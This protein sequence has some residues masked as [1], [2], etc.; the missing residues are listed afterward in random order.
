MELNTLQESASSISRMTKTFFDQT[1]ENERPIENE[2]K[3]LVKNSNPSPEDIIRKLQPLFTIYDI[4]IHP[5]LIS[6][7]IDT[8]KLD[9]NKSALSL[10][11]RGNSHTL[12]SQELFEIDS[13]KDI[14][15]KT[16]PTIISSASN[17][18]K[19]YEY[20]VEYDSDINSLDTLDFTELKMK[21]PSHDLFNRHL[22]KCLEIAENKSLKEW[23]R[24]SVNRTRVLMSPYSYKESLVVGELNIDHVRTL[25]PMTRKEIC[26][27][28]TEIE[29]EILHKECPWNEQKSVITENCSQRE[30]SKAFNLVAMFINKLPN[31]T[32]TT[33]SKADRGFSL[34]L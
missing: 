28:Y 6:R 10:R 20:E 8:N 5:F 21:Y 25:D 18:T 11:I 30:I 16:S 12:E 7:Q 13:R 19:R 4:S 1:N 26:D 32:Q 3:F 29:F 24:L 15:V 2:L 23:F 31:M 14:C 27:P 34:F 22:Y 33:D 17:A 9:M